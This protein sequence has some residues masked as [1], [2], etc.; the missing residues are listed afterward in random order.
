[1]SDRPEDITG[2]AMVSA[3]FADPMLME[4]LSHLPPA[5]MPT[6]FSA[7]VW[8][9]MLQLHREGRTCDLTTVYE[10]LD[11]S[12]NARGMLGNE[13]GL[14]LLGLCQGQL[15]TT[16]PAGLARQMFDQHQ[17]RV[18]RL[19]LE[20]VLADR[21]ADAASIAARLQEITDDADVSAS[22]DGPVDVCDLHRRHPQL[23]SPII[24][25]LLRAGEILNIISKSKVGKS[26]LVYGLALSKAC[27]LDWLG[28]FRCTPGNV[29]LIDYE[30]HPET[31]TYRIR[32]VAEAMG[33]R[34]AD[35]Q[36]RLFIKTL[37]GKWSDVYALGKWLSGSNRDK[38][39]LVAIDALY[40]AMPAGFSENDNAQMTAIYNTLERY[41][42]DVRAGIVCVHHSSKGDQ[43]GKDITDVGSGAG[44]Q[45]RAAD[46][47]LILR[48]HEEEG[49][50]V[51][52]AAVRS[53]KPLEPVVL[54]WT[55]PLWTAADELDPKAI[56]RPA[57]R[58]DTQQDAKDREACAVIV[59]RMRA[60]GPGTATKLRRLTGFGPDRLNRLIR[61]MVE[62]K[63]LIAVPSNVAGNDC[64]EYQL[65]EH[66][67]PADEG[68]S[69][70]VGG[71]VGTPDGLPDDVG[72]GGS[73]CASPIGD[74]AL[75]DHPP[76]SHRAKSPKPKPK[77]KPKPKPRGKAK[78]S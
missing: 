5:A 44:A 18:M 51:L 78:A 10:R 49:C 23:R 58:Q 14:H 75:P 66:L 67:R 38:F 48:P 32:E 36:G 70:V 37:R 34:E 11:Q 31:L 17:A 61:I 47:H 41:A 4:S 9:T 22:S 77:G 59:D 60:K 21:H 68:G 52:D 6:D 73:L 57:T 46:T 33:L 16:N 26:W 39:E 40:R 43:S 42:D 27:G 29:L 2:D 13:W 28:R 7:A 15:M 50:V 55:F 24:E 20:M 45:S 19:R 30:L 65:A 63:R 56:K 62:D 71:V 8:S 72:E 53:F 12:D 54:R 25:D 1:M 74:G 64:D 3:V 69:R 35:Y 76:T